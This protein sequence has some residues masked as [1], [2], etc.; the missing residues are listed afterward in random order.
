MSDLHTQIFEQ[1]VLI[2]METAPQSNKYNQ[3]Y[4]T[5]EQFKKV[6]DTICSIVKT[7]VELRD[8]IEAVSIVTSQ[9]EYTLPDLQ[10]IN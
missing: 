4:L 3:V 1:R 5:P 7:D 8:G 2:F 10:S 9:E 6:S